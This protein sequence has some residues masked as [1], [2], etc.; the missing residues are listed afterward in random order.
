MCPVLHFSV[1]YSCYWPQQLRPS[2]LRVLAQWWP[3]SSGEGEHQGLS[4]LQRALAGGR[5]A[6]AAA[7]WRG[8]ARG[9][10]R[11]VGAVALR[12]VH[13]RLRAAA[14]LL[15]AN[16]GRGWGWLPRAGLG[17]GLRL[18]GRREPAGELDAAVHCGALGFGRDARRADGAR[19]VKVLSSHSG[20]LPHVP[21]KA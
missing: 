15:L 20:P 8:E 6:A 3:W 12:C 17:L 5:T 1:L 16:G 4:G 11:R 10:K 19:L 2:A 18:C 9:R 14:G 13:L 21:P 7:C